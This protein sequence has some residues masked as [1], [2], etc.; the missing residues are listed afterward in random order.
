MTIFEQLENY[1][2]CIEIEEND[3][4]ELVN[5]ISM[6]T[7]WTQKPCETFLTGDREEVVTLPN[8]LDDCGVYTF[9]PFYHPYVVSSFTFSLIEQD[10]IEET[11]IPITEYIYS[12]TDKAFKLKLPLPD[13]KCTP[14]CG[15]EKTYKLRVQYIAG[16]EEIPDC[17]LPVFCSAIE[18]IKDKN[19]CD[20]ECVPCETEEKEG[21]IN[22]ATIR[23]N[24]QMYFLGMLTEQYK[25]QLSLISLCDNGFKTL[26]GFVV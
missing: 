8:C 19:A 24:L 20:C 16:Y 11:D 25:R 7:C 22:V 6:Y 4:V 13:C 26:W 15:C 21:V 14:K 23:G 17:L 12:D 9:T 10:G 2:N 5:L 18:W 3:V 1:C